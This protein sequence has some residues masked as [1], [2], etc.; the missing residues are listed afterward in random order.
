MKISRG[1]RHLGEVQ[2]KPG[3]SFQVSALNRVTR[4][5]KFSPT[6]M[7]ETKSS[8]PGKFIRNL[9]SRSTCYWFYL[10]KLSSSSRENIDIPCRSPCGIN[11]LGKTG[12]AWPRPSD[13]QNHSYPTDYFKISK[14]RSFIWNVQG[15]SNSGL[16]S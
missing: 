12:T 9:V 6:T 13:T 16:L 11:L 4:V 5:Q 7:W 2:E 1:K 10:L 8:K 3:T 15:L 14:D